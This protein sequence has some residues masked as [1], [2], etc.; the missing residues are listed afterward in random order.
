LEAGAG[1]RENNSSK[2]IGVA[3]SI[4]VGWL[5]RVARVDGAVG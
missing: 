1:R 3:K 5:A 2:S 4:G